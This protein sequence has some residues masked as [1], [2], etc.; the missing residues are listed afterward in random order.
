VGEGRDRGFQEKDKIGVSVGRL[1]LVE[2]WVKGPE[3]A[4]ELKYY[5]NFIH[6][7]VL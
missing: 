7:S 3:F 4:A 1:G 6:L 5:L 2:G